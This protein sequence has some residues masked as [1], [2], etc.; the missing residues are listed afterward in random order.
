MPSKNP[1]ITIQQTSKERLH[2]YRR[3]AAR[4]YVLTQHSVSPIAVWKNVSFKLIFLISSRSWG[5]SICFSHLLMVISWKE[6]QVCKFESIEN[7][8]LKSRCVTVVRQS[9]HAREIWYLRSWDLAHVIDLKIY[10]IAVSFYYDR[11]SYQETPLF[12]EGFDFPFSGKSLGFSRKQKGKQKRWKDSVINRKIFGNALTKIVFLEKNRKKRK[13]PL[14]KRSFRFFS[15]KIIFVSLWDHFVT[16]ISYF[17]LA[18][19]RNISW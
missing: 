9:H 1:S 18:I 2:V 11:F 3:T 6:Y 12:S 10:W 8:W 15:E 4:K 5:N 19:S 17:L 13:T 14:S 16:P 7:F